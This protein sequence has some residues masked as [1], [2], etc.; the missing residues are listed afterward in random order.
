MTATGSKIRPAT[1]AT[2]ATDEHVERELRTADRRLLLTN[3][4]LIDQQLMP[5]ETRAVPVSGISRVRYA[6]ERR[7]AGHRVPLLAPLLDLLMGRPVWAL[8]IDTL[9]GGFAFDTESEQDAREMARAISA[10]S[11]AARAQL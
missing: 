7:S 9:A 8:R 4:R 5:M 10:A 6:L 2:L 1:G 11:A 3:F